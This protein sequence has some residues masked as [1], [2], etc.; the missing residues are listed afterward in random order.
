MAVTYSS[1]PWG[2]F[3]T[4][5]YYADLPPVNEWIGRVVLVL[6]S[7]GVWIFPFT[8]HEK[9]W[10]YSDGTTWDK[11]SGILDQ[12]I[13]GVTNTDI[14]GWIIGN[15]SKVETAPYTPV[16]PADLVPISKALTYNI[17]GT[18][19]VVT[20]ARGTKTMAYN[21]DGTLASLTGTGIYN[22]KTFTY[23]GGVLT[24]VTVV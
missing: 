11:K 18:L 2:K 15:G 3:P 7:S 14:S 8:Y 22:S 16:D 5:Q 1:T 20:D 12:I 19:N 21:L 4:V 9:G 17:D 13:D 10:Y 23:V 6:E 24:D